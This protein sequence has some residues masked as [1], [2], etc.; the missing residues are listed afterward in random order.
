M[1]TK[2]SW[3]VIMLLGFSL[4]AGSAASAQEMVTAEQYARMAFLGSSSTDGHTFPAML[5]QAFAEAK[6]PIPLAFNAGVGGNVTT[7]MVARVERDV[8]VHKPSLVVIQA[9][10]N[11]VSRKVPIEEFKKLLS[12]IIT[13]LHENEIPVI[14]LTINIRGEKL[15][16]D[17]PMVAKFN[18]EIRAM[19]DGNNV[20]IADAF[21]LQ[22]KARAAGENVVEKDGLH[23]NFQGQRLIARAIL[24]AMGYNEVPVPAEQKFALYPGVITE[25]KFIASTDGKALDATAVA[26]LKPDDTWTGYSLPETEVQEFWWN[27]GERLRGFGL[28]L[29]KRLG[30]AKR[31]Y[32]VANLESQAERAACIN[33]GAGV[34]AAWLNGKQLFRST[35]Y[36]GWHAGRERLPVTLQAGRNVIVIE[37]ADNFFLSVTDSADW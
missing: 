2:V 36:A 30:K 22:A 6:L 27:D 12:G 5:Q 14:L 19:E 18:D 15:I 31:Y 35:T 4:L 3:G 7:E 17:E 20:R 1:R 9:G 25:W 28:S 11:D 26:A 21:S 16:A 8:L 32:G 23:P 13:V 34:Q 37:A 33:T 29:A 24:D 10:A